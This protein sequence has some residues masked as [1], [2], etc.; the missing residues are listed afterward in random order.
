MSSERG[1]RSEIRANTSMIPRASTIR[2]ATWPLI[3][4]VL[5]GRV[6][7]TVVAL[8]GFCA[9]LA[10]PLPELG[11]LDEGVMVGNK[12][13]E[14]L[15]VEPSPVVSGGRLSNGWLSAFVPPVLEPD[16]LSPDPE[17]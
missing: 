16:E 15:E 9:W 8:Y 5:R 12:F 10:D 7:A 4:P 6:S 1:L 13:D 3:C 17:P 2:P 14:V 11:V